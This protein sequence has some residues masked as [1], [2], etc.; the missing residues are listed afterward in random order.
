[1]TDQPNTPDASGEPTGAN[2]YGTPPPPPPPAGGASGYGTPA[3]PP[4]PGEVPV[5][6]SATEALGYGW[7]GFKN[8]AGSF[9]GLALLIILVGGVFGALGNTDSGLANGLMQMIGQIISTVLAAGMIKGALDVTAGRQVSIGG[10]FEGW[11][12]LQVV[13][14][15]IL[16]SIGTT[17]GLLL[18]IIPGLIFVFLTWFTN[19]FIIEGERSAIDGIKDSISFAS[20]H[21]GELLVLA[22]LSVLTMIVGLICL[23][24]G[25][26]VAIPVVMIAGAYA[27]R[28]LQDQP[29][30]EQA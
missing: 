17:I 10:M 29:I 13:I 1:M 9:L 25:I 21:V 23:I 20:Q 24:V 5:S 2:P 7:R 6:F 19:Y 11:N 8:N 22:L 3:P 12:K 28:R 30:A 14:A 27:F 16:V 18:L 4:P 15:A 26:F